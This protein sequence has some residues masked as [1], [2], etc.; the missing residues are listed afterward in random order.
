M[1]VRYPAALRARGPGRGRALPGGGGVPRRPRGPGPAPL[2]PPRPALRGRRLHLRPAQRARQRR[3]RQG[4]A[5]RRQRPEAPDV[6]TDIEDAG[7]YWREKGSRG[8]KAPKVG[9]TGGSYGGYS[10]LDGHDDVRGDLRRRRRRRGHLEPGDVPARTPPP[11]AALLRATEYGDPEKDAEALQQA[12]AHDLRRPRQG[13]AAPHPGG[14]RPARARGRG[15]PDPRER[16][17]ARGVPVGADPA[18]GRRPR[19]RPGARAR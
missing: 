1:F 7:R 4:L 10:T 19:R 5:R 8:G 6:I 2:Q 12:L 18:R 3:L 15:R 17:Q 9:I 11:T 13:A 16:S 14:R